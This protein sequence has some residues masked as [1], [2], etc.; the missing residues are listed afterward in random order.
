MEFWLLK[1]ESC[2]LC[3]YMF[4]CFQG[5]WMYWLVSIHF[6][7]KMFYQC[8]MEITEETLNTEVIQLKNTALQL[9]V[10]LRNNRIILSRMKLQLHLLPNTTLVLPLV[11]LRLSLVLLPPLLQYHDSHSSSTSTCTINGSSSSVLIRCV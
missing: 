4:L 6:S 8:Y 5:F 3:T 1:Y 7:M 2:K 10:R 9:K 11:I